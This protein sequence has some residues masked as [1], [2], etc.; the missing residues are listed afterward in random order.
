MGTD[1]APYMANLFLY[2]YEFKWIQRTL[3][4]GDLD[5]LTFFRYCGRYIDDLVIVNNDKKMLSLMNQIYPSELVLVPD[6]TDGSNCPFLDLNLSLTDGVITTSVFDK[7]DT[8]NFQIVNF[9][10]LSGNIPSRASYGVFIGE[11]VRYAR[12]L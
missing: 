10:N 8:F 2:A 1:C 3:K 9:P 12:A 11:L 7:R 5:T 4:S 6:S